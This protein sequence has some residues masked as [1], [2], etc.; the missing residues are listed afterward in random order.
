VT[1]RLTDHKR[2]KRVETGKEALME[3]APLPAGSDPLRR[4]KKKKEAAFLGSG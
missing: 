1:K 3:P 2:E 4:R